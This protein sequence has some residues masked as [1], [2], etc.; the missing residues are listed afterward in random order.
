MNGGGWWPF[1]RYGALEKVDTLRGGK[2]AHYRVRIK[3]ESNERYVSWEASSTS[4]VDA[5]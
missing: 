5:E 1:A 2:R 3:L 4:S